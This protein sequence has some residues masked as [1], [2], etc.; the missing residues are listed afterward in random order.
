MP[1]ERLYTVWP[2]TTGEPTIPPEACQ[3]WCIF[4]L[5]ST[6]TWCTPLVQGTKM[7]EPTV[8]APPKEIHT[9]C[10]STWPPIPPSAL[11][12]RTYPL[13]DLPAAKTKLPGRST[14]PCDPRSTSPAFSDAQEVGAN[15]SNSFSV[16]ESFKIESL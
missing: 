6:L 3:P 14:A 5:A 9:S 1:L 11:A 2:P 4:P 7:V 16:G 13:P 12:C 10:A 8:A 15:A